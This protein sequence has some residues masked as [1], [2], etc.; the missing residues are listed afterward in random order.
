VRVLEERA[1]GGRREL[2]AAKRRGSTFSPEARDDN[3]NHA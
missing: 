2:E 1:F 3:V